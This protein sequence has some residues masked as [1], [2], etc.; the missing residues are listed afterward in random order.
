MFGHRLIPAP[1]RSAADERQR[2]NS[3][4]RAQV[5]WASCRYRYTQAALGAA[6]LVLRAF[7]AAE[8]RG[9]PRLLLQRSVLRARE[10]DQRSERQHAFADVPG[11]GD[12]P[13]DRERRLAADG[14]RQRVQLR[15]DDARAVGVGEQRL[16]PVPEEARGEGCI[17]GWQRRARQVAQAVAVLDGL[18]PL[19]GGRE[20]AL[21]DARPGGGVARARGAE[22]G[23]VALE[24][25]RR[26]VG[27]GGGRGGGGPQRGAPAGG[28]RA[29]RGGAGERGP[30][31]AG[32]QPRPP[33]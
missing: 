21:G 25:E 31:G 18:Q 32:G 9:P 27:G 20:V 33:A 16:V 22:G 5:L 17:G 4:N 29:P 2:A 28:P 1:Y 6:F 8:P 19:P 30:R 26:G 3:S 15:R 7:R 23:E 11:A 14:R 10:L 12:A 13:V 24:H